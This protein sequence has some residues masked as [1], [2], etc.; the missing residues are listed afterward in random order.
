MAN[1]IEVND[2]N[3]ETE[4]LKSAIPVVVDFWATWCGPCRAI[5]PIVEEVATETEGKAKVVKLNVDEAQDTAVEYGVRSIP[6]LIFFKDGKET[7]RI[8]GVTD[9]SKIIA[10]LS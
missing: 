9:K 8:V 3:F 5:A 6:T 4:V 7:D 1:L 2:S 10:A